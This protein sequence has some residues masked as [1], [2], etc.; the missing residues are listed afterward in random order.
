[1]MYPQ[2]ELAMYIDYLAECNHPRKGQT[3]KKERAQSIRRKANRVSHES[4]RI[5]RGK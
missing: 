1:M 2:L 4:R 3:K 5:N